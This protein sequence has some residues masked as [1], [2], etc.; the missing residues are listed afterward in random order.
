MKE[1]ER[2]IFVESL[3]DTAKLAEDTVFESLSV[4]FEAIAKLT[5]ENNLSLEQALILMS[6]FLKRLIKDKEN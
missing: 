2:K 3:L 1:L 6:E 5:K 4:L